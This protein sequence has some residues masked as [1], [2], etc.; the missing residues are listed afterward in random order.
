[1]KQDLQALADKVRALSPAQRLLMASELLERGK[2]E[3]AESI[4]QSAL[5]E[6]AFKRLF[7]GR[8]LPK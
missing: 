5:D 2:P 1:M 8:L 6:L 4:A 3:M 7:P